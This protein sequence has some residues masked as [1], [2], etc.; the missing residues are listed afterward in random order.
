M[1]NSV[2]D[3]IQFSLFGPDE[4]RKYSVI[5]VTKSDTYD[6]NIPIIKGPFDPR[7]G[8]C[9]IGQLCKTCGQKNTECPGHFG[10]IELA[11]PIIN[12]QFINILKKVLKCVCFRC[13]KL[14][15]NKNSRSIINLLKKDN[16]TRFNDIS[17]LSSKIKRCGQ[18]TEDGCGAKQPKKYFKNPGISDIY[19]EWDKLVDSGDD[20]LD[21][22]S[23][24][25]L[26]PTENL[27]QLLEKITDEDSEILGFNPKWVRPE[28]LIHTVIP[29]PPP[30]M[31]PS[32]KQDNQRMDDDL[33]YK[34]C[35]IIKVNNQIRK[36]IEQNTKQ[37]VINDWSKVLQYHV[38]TL[39]DNDIPGVAPAIHRSG[40]P[41]K[42]IRQRLKG[43]EGRIRSNLMG[44]RVDY[45]A[46]SV[47]TPDP[48][49]EIDE[50]GVPLKI[51]TNLTYP[52][53]INRFN[54]D[55][56][57]TI[58]KNGPD[59]WPGAKTI[60]KKNGN[61]IN[62][63]YN[64]ESHTNLELGD[65][66]NRHLM[67]GDSVLFNRQPSLHK[68]SM[69]V[70]RVKVMKCNSF[71]LNVSVTPPYNADFDGDEM[72]MHVPQSAN[73]TIELKYLADVPSQIISVR[74]NKP[75]ITIVQDTL[76]GVNRMTRYETIK[77][78]APSFTKEELSSDEFMYSTRL[79]NTNSGRPIPISNKHLS[80][81][82]SRDKQ[83]KSVG[84]I[85][86]N[87]CYFTQG[88]IMNMICNIKTTDEFTGELPIPDFGP[89]NY[90]VKLWS[91]KKILSIIIPDTVNLTMKNKSFD[92]RNVE[93]VKEN[94]IK[95]INGILYEGVLDKDV[96][97]KTSKGLIHTIYNDIGK[98]AAKN[99]LDNL[100]K[101][102]TQFL[103]IDGYSVGISDMIANKV[104]QDKVATIIEKKKKSISSIIQ[105]VHLNILD[106]PTGKS[107]KEF[108]E[109]KV[110]QE[111][112]Q[113]IKE[114]G[115][116]GIEN[117][118]ERNRATNMVNAGSKGNIM[119]ISQMIACI[120][121]QN[122]DGQRITQNFKDR[123]L[124]HFKKYDDN[125]ESR[126]FIENSFITGQTP[127]EFFFQ[128]MAGR[129][130]LID[131]AVK[132]AE[133][134]YIQRKLIKAMEDLHVGY[135]YSVR[136]GSNGVIQLVY[137]N[138]GM[139]AAFVEAQS[140]PLFNGS[141]IFSIKELEDEYMMN[142]KNEWKS[143]LNKSTWEDLNGNK[144]F[145]TIVK[146]NIDNIKSYRKFIAEDLYNL[147]DISGGILFPV[148]FQRIINR[149]MKNKD[150]IKKY[151]LN[152][153]RTVSDLNPLSIIKQNNLLSDKLY[154]TQYFKNNMIFK[155]LLDTY[156]APKKLIKMKMHKEMY[157]E[158]L[159]KIE[160]SYIK[161]KIDPG[162]MV[163]TIA[164]QSIGE[165]ATQMTLNTFHY[166]GISAKSNVT[167]G[168]PRLREVLHITKNMKNPYATIHLMP[169][170]STD[171]NKAQSIMNQLETT[172][173]NDVVTS[174]QIYY[175]PHNSKYS[176]VVEE[177][178]GILNIY[179]EFLDLEDIDMEDFVTS[180]WIIR[181]TF[182]KEL[183]MNKGIIMEDVF[184]AISNYDPD[185][186][187]FIYSDD[188]SSEIVGRLQILT[189]LK[190]EESDINGLSSEND[191]LSILKNLKED[192]LL[193]VEIKGVKN[194]SNIVM[195]DISTKDYFKNTE[196]GEYTLKS[197][198]NMESWILL[199][200]GTNL[201]DLLNN[202]YVDSKNTYSNDIHEIYSIL[203]IEAARA[204]ILNEID[205]IMEDA[206]TN[207]RHTELLADIMTY[208]GKLTPINRQ[209][210]N[211]GD[212]GALA[213]CSFEDTTDQ[214]LKAA[215][216][217]E[218]DTLNGV[219]SNI[220]VGQ[221]VPS[222][223][224]YFDMLLDEE[225]LIKNYEALDD[226]GD[227]D[228]IYSDEDEDNIESLLDLEE[229]S[230][231]CGNENFG[232]S[233]E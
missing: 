128:A 17:I 136:S 99:L 51:A 160:E 97:T 104:T 203:G 222:G 59:K 230:E 11:I 165:P 131:T 163:G 28:Y 214:L 39:I 145:K 118:N 75:I 53:T 82:K 47:I 101:I 76:L 171:K 188:N 201:I 45:S 141:K 93:S 103:L 168:I 138:D 26:L 37:D 153:K 219:S 16:K 112:N 5:E 3:N 191:I 199:T 83:N 208:R 206:Y 215:L 110:N 57:R 148:P 226:D 73:S 130:G 139:N 172:L 167:R 159:S 117:L 195:E 74:E 18:E 2:I 228:I 124:P 34:I 31:R 140:I 29:V 177:D 123:T 212:I 162:E 225:Q 173:M 91:G 184:M 223:T 209:G 77:F 189:D 113:A 166:A 127:Q 111:L 187:K 23:K 192:I 68:S 170:Y 60:L 25:Q 207:K 121:Q 229:D 108:F 24:K 81:K 48:N 132:T 1:D 137:G 194:I 50:L 150:Y 232:F 169:E 42:S 22:T 154:V 46:R 181:F 147:Y 198:L 107:T 84:N 61:L 14:L 79:I 176:T 9:D 102:V 86:I 142:D 70:H 63:K 54:R 119:N 175:D 190:G 88:Q 44:K 19:A 133:T 40:R 78:L 204:C 185:K 21:K 32:V 202:P 115:E 64:A 55:Y 180:P 135:D 178:K 129:V 33:S 183:M 120:G 36:K 149:I 52:V 95:I 146:T 231:Y 227:E 156:C 94:S 90:P 211:T 174:S 12:Y 56:M 66:V 43:K 218:K 217:S 41:L 100:Q 62:I 27:Y 122:I 220:M 233:I 155:M 193:N 58:V 4:I 8:V 197:D 96:F 35:D 143:L 80:D 10:H 144:D 20:L 164:A 98:E 85:R 221:T 65:V 126:G 89:P 179:K 71:R 216:F 7:M 114:A 87:S 205:E 106:N 6:K 38:A 186:L 210:I 67:N 49:I 69:M 92:D 213:K 151:A 200:D 196:T 72:N 116:A 30:S 182:N 158:L 152:R 105:D 224:G 125:M 13:S 134:G 15:V 157:A 109:H 161:S